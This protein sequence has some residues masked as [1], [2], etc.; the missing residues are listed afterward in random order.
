MLPKLSTYIKFWTDE[1][2]AHI[3]PESNQIRKN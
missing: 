2:Y 1:I 3:K